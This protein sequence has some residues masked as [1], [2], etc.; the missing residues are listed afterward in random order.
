ML[1]AKEEEPDQQNSTVTITQ[2]TLCLYI[3]TDAIAQIQNRYN[4]CK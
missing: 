3:Y 4:V 1:K 2:H